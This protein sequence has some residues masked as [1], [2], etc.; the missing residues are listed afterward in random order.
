MNLRIISNRMNSFYEE[1]KIH[2]ERNFFI[3]LST[4]T[5]ETAVAVF[6]ITKPNFIVFLSNCC[7]IA[8]KLFFKGFIA[9]LEFC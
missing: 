8:V 9:F 2:I 7:E 1:H 3:Y 6:P 4:K 5:K